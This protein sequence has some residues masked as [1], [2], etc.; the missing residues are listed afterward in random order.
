MRE[1][2]L[3]AARAGIILDEDMLI[4]SDVRELHA[5]QHRMAEAAEA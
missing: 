4:L 1:R 2:F 5:L 3:M